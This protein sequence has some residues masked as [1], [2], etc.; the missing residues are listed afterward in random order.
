MGR[1]LM[2]DPL[3]DHVS[4]LARNLSFPNGISVN[5]DETFLVFAETF[6]LS[7]NVLDLKSGQLRQIE[8]NLPGY[9]DGVDCAP[10]DTGL[11][12][13]V[14]I[15]AVVP[16]HR[17]LNVLPDWLDRMLRTLLMMM[18]RSL[19]PPAQPYGG[20]AEVDVAQSKIRRI[21][22]DTTAKDIGMLSGVT[23][24]ENKLYLGSL[25]NDFIGVYDLKE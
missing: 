25:E 2:Y 15:S 8:G 22:Q 4:I 17:I 20:V 14:M 9:P 6:G 11:C 19:A 3:T 18:P 1:V 16:V 13:S 23:V 24:H 5:P 10:T 12:Y 7:L 21:L